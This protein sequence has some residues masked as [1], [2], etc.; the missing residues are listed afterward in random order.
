MVG[1]SAAI[2]RTEYLNR[3]R[4]VAVDPDTGGVARQSDLHFTG[5]TLSELMVLWPYRVRTA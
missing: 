1:A 5:F 3:F 4:M 2:R